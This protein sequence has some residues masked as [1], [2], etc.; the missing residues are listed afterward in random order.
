MLQSQTFSTETITRLFKKSENSKN[1]VCSHAP[2]LQL[3]LMPAFIILS[4]RSKAHSEAI[5]LALPANR[6]SV[7]EWKPSAALSAAMADW[8][9]YDCVKMGLLFQCRP[10]LTDTQKVSYVWVL[11][12]NTHTYGLNNCVD[13]ADIRAQRSPSLEERDGFVS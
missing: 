2:V 8:I 4:F 7:N 1:I 5:W 3:L 12:G 6:R 10:G 13:A 11:R 9:R